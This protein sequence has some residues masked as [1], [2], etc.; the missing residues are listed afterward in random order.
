MLLRQQEILRLAGFGELGA[1]AQPQIIKRS[2]PEDVK[3]NAVADCPRR[4]AAIAERGGDD[5]LGLAGA[6]QHWRINANA[7]DLKMDHIAVDK[8]EPL[9]VRLRY[10]QRVAPHLLGQR[11]GTFLKP[12]VIGK[13]A[14]PD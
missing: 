8:A 7:P 3:A 12:G 11:L 13:A 6:H 5:V 4:L 2:Q 1:G 10:V 9:S 14:V